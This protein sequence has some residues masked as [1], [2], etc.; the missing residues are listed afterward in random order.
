MPILPIVRLGHPA[1]RGVA[2]ALVPASLGDAAVQA[3]VE[4]M[5]ATMR[6]ARGVGLAAPQVGLPLQLFV[7][8]LAPP[9]AGAA[10]GADG[11]ADGIADGNEPRAD[12]DD[13]EAGAQPSEASERS[14][15][16]GDAEP[17]IQADRAE[18]A[19]R[20]AVPDRDAVGAIPL[21]VVVNPMLTP[22]A[23]ELVYDWEGCLSIPD[24]RGLVP[25]HPAVRVRGLD[26]QG[27]PLDYVAQGF[28]ARI[29]QH[30]FDHLNG[31]VFLDRMRDL[32]ALAFREEWERYMAV[33]AAEPPDPLDPRAHDAPDAHD[34]QDAHDAKPAGSPAAPA[35]APA[36][37]DPA[38]I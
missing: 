22:Q 37:G 17:S 36:P 27:R 15:P 32:R 5:I 30:E 13:R 1:L 38:V 28:E 19:D 26:R 24:L 23:G 34:A 12:G 3:L 4:D 11:V 14:G 6:A 21:H 25:R 7:Y 33:G 18:R 10:D 16:P 31:V 20:S 35:A 9:A 29:V 2:Q 8:E